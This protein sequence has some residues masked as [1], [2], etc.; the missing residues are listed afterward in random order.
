MLVAIV[1]DNELDGEDIG[2]CETELV[3]QRG[4]HCN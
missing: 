4:N 1:T 2:N 3:R